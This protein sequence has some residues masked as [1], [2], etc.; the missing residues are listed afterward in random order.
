MKEYTVQEIVNGYIV[1]SYEPFKK[2]FV[3]TFDDALAVVRSWEV[4]SNALGV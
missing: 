1:T 2:V 4:Q 3:E